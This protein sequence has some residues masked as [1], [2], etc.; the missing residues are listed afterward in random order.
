[1]SWERGA[2]EVWIHVDSERM[3]LGYRYDM[4]RHTPNGKTNVSTSELNSALIWSKGLDLITQEFNS[5][6]GASTLDYSQNYRY[7]SSST[8]GY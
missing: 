5:R 6:S 4:G 2:R 3:D 7:P 1:M 8:Y